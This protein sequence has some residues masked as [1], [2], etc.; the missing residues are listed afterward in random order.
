LVLSNP[1][2]SVSAFKN[3]LNRDNAENDF[4]MYGKLT[5]SSSE[6]ECLFIERTSQLLKE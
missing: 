6:I 2:Y 4:D 5:D 1:P 3:N